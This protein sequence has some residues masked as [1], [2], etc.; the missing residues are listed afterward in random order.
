MAGRSGKV[1]VVGAGFYGSTTAQRLAE[2]DVVRD[3]RA[4][5]HRRG[6]AR[7]PRARHQPVARRSRASRPQV[8]GQ[9]TGADGGGYEATA[10]LRRR[11]HHRRPAAQARHEPHGPHRDQRAGSCAGSPRTSRRTRP[12]PSIIVVS[13][14]L[15][16]MTAL[17]PARDRLPASS[18][19]IGQAGM[20][21]TARFTLLRRR[22]AR[23][24]G[25]LG[26]DPDARLAR[27][28]DGAGAVAL[29]RRR[30]AAVRPAA[31]RPDRR[32]RRPHP[33]RRRRGR[34]AAQD[35]LGLLRAVRRRRAH[36]AR[37]CATTPA[38]SCRCARGSTAST[39]SPA[40]T[41]ASR[42]RSARERRT[43]GRRDRR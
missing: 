16:E 5:R 14:P 37:P 17:D 8:V 24:P 13:N 7:G 4:D 29:H 19:V 40:S 38:R 12:T 2:Y 31:R 23:R 25:R 27:R 9:T 28:H 6:Q 21:D 20:L 15:D 30:Q 22:G 11:R 32:A 43:Q 26:A 41:S 18:R 3:R 39:A 34:G 10:G 42:P 36:G 33:Q 35:R 1:T